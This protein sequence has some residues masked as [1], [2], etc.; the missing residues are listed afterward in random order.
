[1]SIE[2]R[3]TDSGSVRW[4]VRGRRPSGRQ[5]S[6]TFRTKREAE[7]FE[8]DQIAS[9]ARGTWVDPTAGQILFKDWAREWFGSN[10]H[11]WKTATIERNRIALFVHWV[12][13]LGDNALNSIG[14]RQ[15]QGVV[16]ELV[17]DLAPV[18]VRGYYGTVRSLFADAVEM[19][20]IGRSPCRSIKLPPAR[21][22]EKAVV[23]PGELHRLADAIGED[24]RCLIY[25]AGVL[26]LRFGEAAALR[27]GDLDLEQGRLRITRSLAEVNGH[28]EIARP[29]TAAS[30]RSLDIPGPLIEEIR[31]HIDRR[32]LSGPDSLLFTD[33]KGG[34]VRRSNFRN[35]VFNPAVSDAGVDGLTFHGL[36]HSAATRWM[37]SG[38]DARTA[39]RMLGHSDPRLV[40]ELYAHAED[41]ALRA[42]AQRAAEDFWGD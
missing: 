14:P 12:P 13:R 40:L 35:R 10:I 27:L 37:A 34:P 20:L 6:R 8:A 22:K 30:V 25:L 5:Y 23:G 19:D 7:A 21:S 32:G 18:S 3:V 42:A 28:V 24:W 2:R 4:D 15:V 29:K 33:S 31:R 41:E 36:R 38:T 1:M 39:Q 26:G 17:R 9:R 16:N 11:T